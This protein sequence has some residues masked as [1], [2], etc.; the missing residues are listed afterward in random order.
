MPKE[1]THWLIAREIIGKLRDHPFW[2]ENLSA[3][4]NIFQLGTVLPDSPANMLYG[5]QNKILKKIDRRL[6]ESNTGYQAVADSARRNIPLKP[7]QSALLA[8]ILSHFLADAV[9]HPFVFYF[10]NRIQTRHYRLETYLD[11]YYLHS[12][13]TTKRL[14][15][16]ELLDHIEIGQGEF[17]RLIAD[18]FSFDAKIAPENIAVMLNL[19]AGIQDQ[20]DK[21]PLR[22]IMHLLSFLPFNDMAGKLALFYPLAGPEPGLL[23]P[24]P[25]SFRHPVTGEKGSAKVDDLRVE[26]IEKTTGILAQA[27]S[28]KDFRELLANF[29]GPSPTTGLP[30]VPA[31]EM[32][33]F[34]IESDIM[35]VIL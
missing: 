18:F 11:L 14:T 4:A 10:C 3:Y 19:H 27:T 26:A 24:E 32:T 23:F 7:P 9:F 30:N 6:H 13:R 17:C 16:R 28:E 21:R 5:G 15:C 34:D 25:L 20:Y 33:Y 2:G 8:G 12:T 31:A 22:S 1:I 35:E 29:E